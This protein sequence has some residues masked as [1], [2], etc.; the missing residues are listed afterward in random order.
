MARWL[1]WLFVLGSL[2]LGAQ[3]S[4]AADPTWSVV[5]TVAY[6]QTSSDA[7]GQ[8]V[9]TYGMTV[10]L[11]DGTFDV[12]AYWLRFDG[13]TPLLA[14]ASPE[15]PSRKPLD[16]TK[17]V[18]RLEVTNN[19]TQ[20]TFTQIPAELAGAQKFVMA[21]DMTGQSPL[22]SGVLQIAFA[23][24]SPGIVRI[25]A[26]LVVAALLG[27]VL[28]LLN[29]GHGRVL[30]TG[31]GVG[32]LKAAFLDIETRTYSLSKVQFY[33]W[34]F[35]VIAGYIYLTLARSLVQG[36]FEFAS[37]PDNLPLLLG[38][39]VGTTVVS[40]AVASTAGNKGAGDVG[41]LPSDLIT[42][43]GVVAPER[44]L[45]LLWTILGGL[46]FLLF[47]FSIAP[48]TINA[49]PSV[50]NGFLE[51]MGV[52]AAGYVGGK[53]AR[54]PGPNIQAIVREPPPPDGQAAGTDIDPLN[55]QIDG[56]NLATEGASYLMTQVHPALN[57][58]DIPVKLAVPFR[59]GS[60]V[61]LGKKTATRIKTS[62]AKIPQ[63]LEFKV[64][65]RYQFTIVNPDGEKAS[66]EFDITS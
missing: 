19:K 62:V 15:P 46:A 58:P 27:I 63:K 5:P 33:I 47:A 43:G 2:V 45:H 23:M 56:T 22:P 20:A 54:G 31:T 59:D 24:V 37:I 7:Q 60:V 6:P 57:Q 3:P 26:G 51:L 55:I 65:N 39:S 29:S 21:P 35:A 36:A 16:W 38:I 40:V 8:P 28:L 41:P 12:P 13:R 10:L 18:A 14:C 64:G 48:E 53:I 11:K 34:G 49:L 17:C 30:T 61:D 44:L 32:L 9:T 50:P 1:R 42:S 25:A 4:L 52:S 66:W